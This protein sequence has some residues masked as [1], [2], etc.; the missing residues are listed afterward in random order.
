MGEKVALAYKLRSLSEG[1]YGISVLARTL[2]FNRG[3]FYRERVLEIK[4]DLMAKE[5]ER[6]HTEEDDTLTHI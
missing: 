5:I 3:S 1:S 4:D 2:N 6:I